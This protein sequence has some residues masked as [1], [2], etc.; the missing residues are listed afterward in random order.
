MI[1]LKIKQQGLLSALLLGISLQVAALPISGE[2]GFGGSFVPVDSS[3]TPTGA[4]SATGVDFT[5]D[6]M[7]VNTATGDFAGTPL[8]GTITDFQFD[9]FLGINDGSG[10]VTAVVSIPDFWT[11]GGFSFELTSITRGSSADPDRFLALEGTGVITAAGFDPTSAV[12]VFTGNTAGGASFGWSAGSTAVSA[13]E[14]G[15]LAL[16]GVGLMLV[17][18]GRKLRT[19]QAGSGFGGTSA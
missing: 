12:W 1:K 15:M 3:W 11:A 8:L 14:P 17:A 6:M 2:I 19:T 7:I 18:G 16:L 4:A 10:G 13:P 9:P 5:P